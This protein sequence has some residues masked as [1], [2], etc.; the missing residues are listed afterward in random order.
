MYIQTPLYIYY[1]YTCTFIKYYR[2]RER[3]DY[4]VRRSA[5][6]IG[7]FTDTSKCVKYIIRFLLFFLPPPFFPKTL[8]LPKR[9]TERHKQ[10][11]SLSH[12]LTLCS[13]RY[14]KPT[15]LLPTPPVV[16]SKRCVQV[17]NQSCINGTGDIG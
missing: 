12:S 2:E 10:N 14:T 1:C 3:E 13:Y 17:C 15:A 7:L 8:F 9:G 5:C 6:Y 4:F 11:L 16:S